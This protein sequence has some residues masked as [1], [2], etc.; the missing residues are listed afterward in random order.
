MSNAQRSF[1][2]AVV[3][4]TGAVG[5]TM[6][7]ILEERDFPA[8]TLSGLASARSA[9]RLGA[10]RNSARAARSWRACRASSQ[11]LASSTVQVASDASASAIITTYTTKSEARYMP[12]GVS[13]G[14]A[15][16][17]RSAGSIVSVSISIGGRGTAAG[18]AVPGG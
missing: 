7:S 3:G 12:Q 2:V 18:P 16:G 8:G 9:G 5:E 6:L 15:T 17:A 14:A 1:H 4:A 11:P 13:A 10:C